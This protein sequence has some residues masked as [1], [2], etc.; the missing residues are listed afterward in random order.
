MNF[1]KED[2][3][4]EQIIRDLFSLTDIFIFYNKNKLYNILKQF[5]EEEDNYNANKLYMYYQKESE[6]KKKKKK[7]LNKKKK[8]K[9]KNLKRG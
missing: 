1:K 9:L 4:K 2:I 7:I 3:N 6:R 5:K 8:K